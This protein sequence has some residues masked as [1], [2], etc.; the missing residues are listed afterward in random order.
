MP[1]EWPAHVLMATTS[2]RFSFPP[3]TL[4]LFTPLTVASRD[5]SAGAFFSASKSFDET[6]SPLRSYSSRMRDSRNTS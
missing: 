6:L 5:G 3:A 2:G 1:G 4:T